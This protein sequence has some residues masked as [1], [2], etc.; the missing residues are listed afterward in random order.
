MSCFSFLILLVEE[1]G[2][3]KVTLPVFLF[4]IFLLLGCM[5]AEGYKRQTIEHNIQMTA[6][7]ADNKYYD[8]ALTEISNAISLDPTDPRLYL[9]RGEIYRYMDRFVDAT[10]D[11]TFVVDHPTGV[12]EKDLYL[13][14]MALLARVTVRGQLG[15][16]EEALADS[17]RFLAIYDSNKAL[18]DG[19]RNIELK[20]TYS[21]LIAAIYAQRGIIFIGLKEY[22]KSL[23]DINTSLDKCENFGEALTMRAIALYTRGLVYNELRRYKEALSDFTTSCSTGYTAACAELEKVKKKVK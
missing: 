23:Q 6:L 2:M 16:Y 19:E 1:L 11:Y 9:L 22:D 3:K 14:L 21:R 8:K 12:K 7:Y 20:Q 13:S 18:I 4:S 5:T 10:N 15:Q 17:D